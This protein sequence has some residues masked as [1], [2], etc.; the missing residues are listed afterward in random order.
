[1]TPQQ[2]EA[3]E[4]DDFKGGITA[5]LFVFAVIWLLFF[6]AGYLSEYFAA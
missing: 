6:A 3:A 5:L 4:M 2:R 1:M